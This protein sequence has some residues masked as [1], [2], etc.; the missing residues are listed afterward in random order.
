MKASAIRALA[1]CR[2]EFNP[3]LGFLG[4]MNLHPVVDSGPLRIAGIKLL[5]SQFTGGGVGAAVASQI[6]LRHAV[7][8]SLIGQ[9]EQIAFAPL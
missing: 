6:A 8:S 3:S 1:E 9:Y 7:Y 4:K 2:G 5:I